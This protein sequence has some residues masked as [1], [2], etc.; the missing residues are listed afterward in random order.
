MKR[1]KATLF[2]STVNFDDA[3]GADDCAAGTADASVFIYHF[4]VV[5]TFRIYMFGKCD[6]LV[7]A[8]RDADRTALALFRVND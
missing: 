7:G 1:K 4:K 6:A 2:L 8:A 3:V 5:V